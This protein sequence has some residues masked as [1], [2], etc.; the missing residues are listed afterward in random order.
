MLRS[1]GEGME[2][3]TV[4]GWRIGLAPVMRFETVSGIRLTCSTTTPIPHLVDGEVKYKAAW[5][6]TGEEVMA[7]VDGEGF[8]WEKLAKQ[9]GHIGEMAVALISAHNGVYAAGDQRD[10][11]IFT[12]NI[13][14]KR[15]Y[16]AEP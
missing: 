7:V 9:P 1:D 13:L 14:Y 8:R 6:C 3:G 10:R 15:E 2:P 5:E 4:E 16:T 12:H 11:F